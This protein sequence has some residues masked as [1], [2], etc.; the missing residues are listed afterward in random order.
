MD[1]QHL[2]FDYSTFHLYG[3]LVGAKLHGSRCKSKNL[4]PIGSME[5]LPLL[6]EGNLRFSKVLYQSKNQICGVFF[7]MFFQAKIQSLAPQKGSKPPTPQEKLGTQDRP[8]RKVV[9]WCSEGGYMGITGALRIPKPLQKTGILRTQKRETAKYQI[10]LPSIGGSNRWYCYTDRRF[11]F[12][13]WEGRM[14][15]RVGVR[16]DLVWNSFFNRFGDYQLLSK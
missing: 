7:H 12:F 1:L 11:K 6:V 10:H 9:M 2:L 5:I 16:G 8:L 4:Q 15:L 3:K 14:I 13:R